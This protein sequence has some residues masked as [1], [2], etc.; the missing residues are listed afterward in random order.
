MGFCAKHL[1]VT[2]G[3]SNTRCEIMTPQYSEELM[4]TFHQMFKGKILFWDPEILLLHCCP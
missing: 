2:D 1:L 4:R 3:L